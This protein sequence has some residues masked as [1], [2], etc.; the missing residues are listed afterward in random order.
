MIE[1][2]RRTREADGEQVSQKV[3]FDCPK[4]VC[5]SRWSELSHHFSRNGDTGGHVGY[6]ERPEAGCRSSARLS[7]LH[8]RVPVKRRMAD[9]RVQI[10]QG[11]PDA[12][13]TLVRPE[14]VKTRVQ[15]RM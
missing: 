14:K 12:E 8:E 6:P 10:T 15:Q 5:T 1:R 3:P 9:E 7:G 4:R 13:P 2:G 11:P